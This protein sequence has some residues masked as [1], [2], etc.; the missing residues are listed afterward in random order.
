MRRIANFTTVILFS[1]GSNAWS[2]TINV[3]ADQGTIQLGIDAAVNGDEVLVANGTYPEKINF[4][5]KAITVRSVNGAA[6]TTIDGTGLNDSVVKCVSGEGLDTVF[7]AFTV[8]GGIAF[9]GG[10]MMIDNGSNPTVRN[11]IFDSN[12][13]TSEGGGMANR[14]ASSPTVD[15]CIFMLNTSDL[16][17]GGI[18]NRG[19]SNPWVGNCKFLDNSAFSSAGAMGIGGSNAIIVINCL[20]ARNSVG[21][22]AGA[23]GI[24]SDGLGT[25]F[26]NCTFTENSAFTS[27]AMNNERTTTY[28]T[29]CIVWNNTP[30]GITTNTNGGVTIVTYSVTQQSTPGTGNINVDPL[31]VDAPGGDYHL[32]PGSPCI[33]AGDNSVV[34]VSTDLD[35]GTRIVNGTVDMGPYE[36][37]DCNNNAILDSLE[38]DTDGDGLIDDCDRCPINPLFGQ[39]FPRADRDQD[40]DCDGIDFAAFASCFNKAGNPPRTAGCPPENAAA[41]DFFDDGDVDGVDFS[42]FASCYNGSGNPPREENCPQ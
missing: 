9:E 13:A 4:G 15:N 29:N 39:S 16:F 33:D 7:D 12:H 30:S 14:G 18:S 34:S 19:N 38:P 41:F 40:C 2:A 5:G 27:G 22:Q 26:I 23:I 21:G 42:I 1:C 11:C 20:F 6:V 17:S 32:Q 3:P 36:F 8:T 35:G 37:G 24:G 25:R 28:V 31:F 10:G